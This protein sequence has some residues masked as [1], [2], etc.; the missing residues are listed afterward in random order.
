MDVH[1]CLVCR[2]Q[3]VMDNGQE[4]ANNGNQIQ[5]PC[6]KKQKRE[7][8]WNNAFVYCKDLSLIVF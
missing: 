4:K 5:H 3:A 8:L 2:L 7:M 1:L 6:F